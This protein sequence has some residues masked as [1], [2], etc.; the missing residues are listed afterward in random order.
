MILAARLVRD[1]RRPLLWWSLG[2]VGLVLST[3]ALFPTVQGQESF[4]QLAEQL[5][6]AM[7][8]AFGIDDAIP[9]TSPSGYLHGRL[10]ASLVPLVLLVFGIGVGAR[11]IAGSE[12]EGTL[13]LLLANP[14][15]R[16][17]VVTQRFVAVVAMLGGLTAVFSVSLW[18]LALPFGALEGVPAT[19][20]AG[21]SA[22]LF[23]IALLHASVSFAVG[24]ATG[25]R[26]WALATA[27][28]VAVAG[29]LVQGL[30]GV[31]DAVRSL[32]FFSP[33]H[34]YLGRNM[35][36]EGVAPDA[37]A[38]PLVLAALLFALALGAF[39]RRDLR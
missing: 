6:E 25:R 31:S 14:V 5:P 24:A 33:W 30:L 10:F 19:G 20:L 39:R 27:T 2:I 15:T 18:A 36:A 32:R 13:E 37:V 35:L 8:S 17:A 12:Q 38:V 23:G 16:S 7:R 1:R 21:A 28:T 4:D 26:T 9:L 22:G 3:V 34:W 11:A 29:Y